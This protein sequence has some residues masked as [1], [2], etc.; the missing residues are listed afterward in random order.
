M[1][2][3][4]PAGDRMNSNRSA[5][6]VTGSER[7]FEAAPE[8]ILWIRTATRG[9]GFLASDLHAVHSLIRSTSSCVNRPFVRPYSFV[10]R[11]LSCAAIDCEGLVTL[12]GHGRAA[13]LCVVRLR[14]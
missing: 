10:V 6:D 7:G 2:S 11:G 3:E 14:Q 9:K 4:R 13:D 12:V 1:V 8:A 5:D